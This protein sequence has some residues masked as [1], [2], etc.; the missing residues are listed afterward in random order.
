MRIIAAGCIAGLLA[1]C[2]STQY[3]SRS[4]DR[5]IAIDGSAAEWDGLIEYP[6]QSIP[7][8]G[9]GAVSDSDHLYLC[10]TSEDREAVSKMLMAGFFITFQKPK[11]KNRLFGINFPLGMKGGEPEGRKHDPDEWAGRLESS[12]QMLALIGPGVKDTAF[13]PLSRAESLGIAVRIKAQSMEQCTYELKVPVAKGNTLPYAIVPGKDSSITV[14]LESGALRRPALRHPQ[15]TRHGPPG[16]GE[17]P[18][19]GGGGPR[20][21]GPGFGSGG[22]GFGG[23]SPGGMHG[24]PPGMEEPLKAVFSLKLSRSIAMGK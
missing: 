7:D 8:L 19:G 14:T 20:G 3:I 13:M 16:G 12:L 15:S 9:I 1:G 5:D 23:G 17:G 21:G 2:S 22:P 11:E 24:P 18:D 10:L 4:R 6:A